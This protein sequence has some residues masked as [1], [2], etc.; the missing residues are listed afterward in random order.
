[1]KKFFAENKYDSPVPYFFSLHGCADGDIKVGV[2][3]CPVLDLS[4]PSG[5]SHP[6]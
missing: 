2:T 5:L 3:L 6:L 1:M 4:L